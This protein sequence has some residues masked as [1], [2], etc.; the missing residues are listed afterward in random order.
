MKKKYVVIIY[1][2]IIN[3]L[4]I[5][6]VIAEC[7]D[8]DGGKDYYIKGFVTGEDEKGYS[9]NN[10]AEA[11]LNA[12]SA[13]G[14]EVFASD[15]LGEFYCEDNLVKG[16]IYICPNGCQNGVCISESDM[17]AQEVEDFNYGLK[18]ISPKAGQ[19]LSGAVPFEIRCSP[20]P[21]Y[22]IEIL[23][24]KHEIDTE[25]RW[26]ILDKF[27]NQ[28]TEKLNFSTNI[29]VQ[30]ILDRYV[31]FGELEKG[32]SEIFD[33]QIN[34][35]IDGRGRTEDLYNIKIVPQNNLQRYKFSSIFFVFSAVIVVIIVIIIILF[36]I[37]RKKRDIVDNR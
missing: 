19:T 30:K 34:V 3:I 16:D 2:I 35:K 13:T 20:S 12:P 18:V 6:F 27:P 21:C 37:K 7:T 26:Y 28:H 25:I 36:L 15:Y 10:Q 29:N 11:C 8:S 9:Y 4:S 14:D 22:D 32:E 31:G 24:K 5:N 17:Q 33:L 23:F 1:L